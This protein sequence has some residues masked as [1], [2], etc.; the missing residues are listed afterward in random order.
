MTQSSDDLLRAVSLRGRRWLEDSLLP[1]QAQILKCQPEHEA[2]RASL[3]DPVACLRLIYGLY[4]FSRRSGNYDEL[5]RT[6]VKAIDARPTGSPSEVY[7]AFCS[8]DPSFENPRNFQVV[9]GLA[10]LSQEVCG[11]PGVHSI[12]DW[13]TQAA[14]KTQRVEKAFLRIVEIRGV[15]PKLASVIMRDFIEIAQLELSILA[16]DQIYMQPINK[17]VRRFATA[18]VPELDPEKSADWILAGKIAKAA[19]AA[20]VSGIRVNMGAQTIPLDEPL[21]SLANST[22]ATSSS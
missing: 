21:E 1:R 8:F 12:Y 6:A 17:Q 19:R 10:E 5:A 13:I 22:N 3:I 2:I 18:V 16:I 9:A 20:G 11:L 15:G 14:E 7:R 4:A